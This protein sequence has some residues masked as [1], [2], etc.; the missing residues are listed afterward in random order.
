M[1]EAV[2]T[3]GGSVLGVVGA[4]VRLV[5]LPD[6]LPVGAGWTW[7]GKEFSAPL[8]EP[9]WG[10]R[11]LDGVKVD[12]FRVEGRD[13][14]A[15]VNVTFPHKAGTLPQVETVAGWVSV[16]DGD[17]VVRG[18]ADGER[19]DDVSVIAAADAAKRLA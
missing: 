5:S 14:P 6:G 15:G 9:P 4:G 16:S 11:R 2:V 10:V 18:R 17:W 1:S 8:P 7:D 13:F 19:V 12:A 3:D